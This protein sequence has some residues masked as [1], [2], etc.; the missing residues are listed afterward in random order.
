METVFEDHLEKVGKGAVAALT[1][2]GFKAQYVPNK[3]AA[4]KAVLKLV[5]KGATVGLGGSHTL[6]ALDMTAALQKHGNTVFNHQ[7]L[8]KE[9]ALKVRR[10]E[11]TADVFMSSSN[12][13]TLDGELINVDGT[14]NRVAA[15]I[16][17][18]GK[19]II[20]AGANKVVKDE[21][22]GRQRIKMLAAPLNA[23]R[24]K[25]KNPCVTTGFCMDCHSPQRICN[26]TTILHRPSGAME[27]HVIIIGESLG[28]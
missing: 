9:D 4:V 11:I 10:Q 22:A 25:L 27:T 21:A 15:M 6:D 3:A 14:G 28:Y 17:G 8:S 13:I 24:L 26:M 12:A 18:P 7:G 5:D 1:K 2:N 20:V 19:I 23:D 16:F